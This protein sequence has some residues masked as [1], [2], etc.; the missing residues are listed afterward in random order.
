MQMAELQIGDEVFFDK[1]NGHKQPI[2]VLRGTVRGIHHNPYTALTYFRLR[3]D[4]TRYFYRQAK[5]LRPVMDNA[6]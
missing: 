4:K 2:G 6:A 3:V 5:S 1:W